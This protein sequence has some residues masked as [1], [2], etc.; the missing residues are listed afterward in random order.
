MSKT[1]EVIKENWEWVGGLAATGVLGVLVNP[2]AWL[3]KLRSNS[4]TEAL[5]AGIQKNKTIREE[6]NAMHRDIMTLQREVRTMR[7]EIHQLKI[8]KQNLKSEN[9]VLQRALQKH[10]N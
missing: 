1:W 10:N 7:D 3:R 8:E 9:E 5:R 4:E 2:L 6:M